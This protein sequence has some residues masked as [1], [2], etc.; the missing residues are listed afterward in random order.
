MVFT[1]RFH[2]CFHVFV[3]MIPST[4]AV[5][6]DKNILIMTKKGGTNIATFLWTSPFVSLIGTSKV[7]VQILRSEGFEFS[8][9]STTT[10]V[11]CTNGT[12]Y[13]KMQRSTIAIC[14]HQKGLPHP[15]CAKDNLQHPISTL[16]H[17]H[18]GLLCKIPRHS[19]HI[20]RANRRGIAS[21]PNSFGQKV[22][23][24]HSKKVQVRP[25]CAYERA[26]ICTMVMRSL[27]PRGIHD[28]THSL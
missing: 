28:T 1:I 13:S 8:K 21:I 3:T 27:E 9:H 2:N 23:L 11:I 22:W 19:S 16:A 4:F 5:E 26:T 17:Y 24:K 10:F 18:R 6:C 12:H 20:A 25:P 14:I 7:Q 15:I